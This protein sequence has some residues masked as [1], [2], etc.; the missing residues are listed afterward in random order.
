MNTNS[1]G[2][3]NAAELPQTDQ[4]RLRVLHPR[5]RLGRLDRPKDTRLKTERVVTKG[6]NALTA[7]DLRTQ[8]TSLEKHTL[9]R[10]NSFPLLLEGF[11]AAVENGNYV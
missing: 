4:A 7:S 8:H 5:L 1:Q 6:S 9:S 11:R 3:G 10:V 2:L